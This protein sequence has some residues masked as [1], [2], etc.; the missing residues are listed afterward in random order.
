MAEIEYDL[1][2]EYIVVNKKA[3]SYFK[4]REIHG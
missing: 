1:D 3:F 4:K 2:I